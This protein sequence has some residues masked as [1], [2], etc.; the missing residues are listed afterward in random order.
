MKSLEYSYSWALVPALARERIEAGEHALTRIDRSETFYD[1]H[2]IGEALI[3]MQ[4]EAMR[5]AGANKP[6]GKAYNQAWTVLADETPKLAK[7]D[8]ATRSN[9]VWLAKNWATVEIWHA[10]LPDNRRR[11]I[12][13]PAVVHRQFNAD[14]PVP[15]KES[16]PKPDPYQEEFD[17]DEEEN[18]EGE[19]FEFFN[20]REDADEADEPIP[21]EPVEGETKE[22]WMDAFT[23]VWA[24]GLIEWR[25]EA[26]EIAFDEE[27][28]HDDERL[29]WKTIEAV[30]AQEVRT[31][32]KAIEAERVELTPE[33]VAQIAA[34][35]AAN[36]SDENPFAG[37]G[38][39]L[40]GSMT[41]EKVM[42]RKPHLTPIEATIIAAKL[43][44][45]D[46]DDKAISQ[47]T[48]RPASVVRRALNKNGFKERVRL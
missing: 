11:I 19:T 40:G 37:L 23:R 41:P 46:W 31:D 18:N 4:T 3:E 9:A 25:R 7:L 5:Q 34:N 14:H 20:E 15:R 47:E 12:N 36:P 21:A 22:Q 42:A 45:P 33:R 10:N 16:A 2:A 13:H 32:A 24:R 29:I 27:A 17:E 43:N 48:K 35:V 1:W 39:D 6:T 38:D 28:F 44:H 26:A 8:G 30:E